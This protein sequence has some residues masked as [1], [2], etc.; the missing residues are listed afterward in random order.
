MIRERPAPARRRRR[1]RREEG[2][3]ARIEDEA[4]EPAGEY[5]RASADRFFDEFEWYANALRAA[6]S[7]GTPY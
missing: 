7:V 5:R 6:R 4:G 1:S 2:A 3:L